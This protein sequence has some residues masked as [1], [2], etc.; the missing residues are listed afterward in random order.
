M[1]VY[2]EQLRHPRRWQR[3]GSGTCRS[4]SVVSR[5][6]P[7]KAP[8]PLPIPHPLNPQTT[9]KRQAGPRSW[10]SHWDWESPHQHSPL[11]PTLVRASGAAPPARSAGSRVLCC[12][13]APPT[14]TEGTA[15]ATRS[16]A[17]GTVP[18]SEQALHKH[19]LNEWA[20][21]GRAGGCISGFLP[22][23]RQL[24][25][26]QEWTLLPPLAAGAGSRAAAFPAPHPHP[27][28]MA[29][30]PTWISAT[31]QPWVGLFPVRSNPSFKDFFSLPCAF[32]SKASR[33]LQPHSPSSP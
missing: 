32:N 18:G 6:P 7:A 29:S 28:P 22:I 15:L 9:H 23:V 14:D 25:S 8:K 31:A 17:S 20:E 16:P 1:N 33:S 27:R 24:S 10:E 12:R 30:P 3:G 26:R 19:L 4:G 11:V 13:C 5:W 21:E 2:Q